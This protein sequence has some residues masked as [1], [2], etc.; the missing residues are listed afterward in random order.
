MADKDVSPPEA[1]VPEQEVWT[2]VTETEDSE[3]DLIQ[4]AELPNTE[5]DFSSWYLR[6]V[7]KELG[8]D[9]EKVRSASDF[10]DSSLPILINALQQGESL[11]S[12][13]EKLRIVGATK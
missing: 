8:E 9:L 13:D 7:T 6:Q 3:I 5:A 4:L 10:K 11:F 12:R 1:D 2:A